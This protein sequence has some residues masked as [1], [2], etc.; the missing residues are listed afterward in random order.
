M[1]THLKR[2]LLRQ[3]VRARCPGLKHMDRD[4]DAAGEEVEE[5]SE[6]EEEEDGEEEEQA[7]QPGEVDREEGSQVRMLVRAGWCGVF[8][9]S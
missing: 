4:L 1:D 8:S 7:G 6:D 3:A 2:C 5:D 9:P